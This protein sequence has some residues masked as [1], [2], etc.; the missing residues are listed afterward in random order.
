MLAV[1]F[2][3]K[4]IIIII[5]LLLISEVK[6]QNYTPKKID[7]IISSTF[8]LADRNKALQISSETYKKAEEIGYYPGQAKSL[9]SKIN[10]YLGLGEQ[11]KALAAADQL[12][13]IAEKENDNYHSAQA[14]I[15]K[16]LAYAYL[17]FFEKALKTSKEAESISKKITDNDDY[18]SCLGQIY[19][20]RSEILNLQY[21]SPQNTLKYDLQSIAYYKKIKNNKKRNG[22]LAIQYSSL[23]YTYIDLEDYKPAIYYSRKAYELSKIEKDSINQAFGLYGIGNA[24]LEMNEIDS[25]IYYYKQALPIF[26]KAN[27]IYRL[28]YI[29]DDLSTLYDKSG[30]DRVYAYYSKKSK[31]ISEVIRKKE[32]IE[33]E[34]VSNS[35]VEQEK[36]VWYQNLYIII[37]SIIFLASIFFFFTITYFKRYKTEKEQNQKAKETLIEAEEELNHLELKV[38]DAFAELIELAK[39]NDSSFLSRFREVYPFFYSKLTTTYP[40]LT[41]G[42]IQFCA[43]LKLNF[44]TKEIATYSNISVRS[45]ETKK[46]RL[47]KQLDIPSEV[48]LNKWMMDF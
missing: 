30:D 12:F 39:N 28:Q 10:A 36:L 45:V 29:Y 33:T 42:Q 22:W 9:N 1:N 37:G 4:S 47:R 26:E 25:S 16:T 34:K 17:G 14:L 44:S 35:I 11:E 13:K 40:E 6:G 31:E 3:K 38:N 2:T 20:G 21:Q 5:L 19:S 46:N 8:Q 43:L 32:K 7:S 27:D 18:Y 41:N 15:A 23:G 24:Y 48:D